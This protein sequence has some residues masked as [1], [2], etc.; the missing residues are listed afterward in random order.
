MGDR[1]SS[2][3]GCPNCGSTAHIRT[4]RSL[5]NKSR[6]LYFQC[7]NPDC[8]TVFKGVLEVVSIVGESKLPCAARAGDLLR[9][10]DRVKTPD[11][12]QNDMFARTAPSG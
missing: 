3:M 4:S 5:S 7:Q 2:R 11:P 6:E 9:P 8:E 10:A 1:R 12:N